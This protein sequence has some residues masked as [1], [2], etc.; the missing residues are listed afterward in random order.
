[1]AHATAVRRVQSDDSRMTTVLMWLV[2]YAAVSFVM[3]LIVG[4]WLKR[5]AAGREGQ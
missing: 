5:R 3:G 1:M 2:A 4:A